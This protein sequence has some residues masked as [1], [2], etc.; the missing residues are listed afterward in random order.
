LE[1]CFL[2]VVFLLNG[3]VFTG[4]SDVTADQMLAFST[5]KADRMFAAINNK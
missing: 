5:L 2:L 1:K 4:Q 3:F